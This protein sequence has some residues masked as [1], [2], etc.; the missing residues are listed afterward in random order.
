LFLAVALLSRQPLRAAAAVLM[1]NFAPLSAARS[2]R[3]D[4][5]NSIVSI[6]M[7]SHAYAFHFF[8]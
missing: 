6:L 5:A 4:H 3:S 8:F 1:Y 2:K 7:F